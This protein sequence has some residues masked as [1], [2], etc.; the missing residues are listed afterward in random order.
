MPF[1]H[2]PI[3]EVFRL[4]FAKSLYINAGPFASIFYS[5]STP[6]IWRCRPGNKPKQPVVY[7]FLKPL[8]RFTPGAN[9]FTPEGT[10]QKRRVYTRGN[11][12]VE[13]INQ[14]NTPG[15]INQALEWHELKNR[16]KNLANL[17]FY[18]FLAYCNKV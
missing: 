8:P 6:H 13:G 2:L 18:L 15:G 9:P 7:T 12:P 1:G 17:T 4:A 5:T 3:R 11:K 14:G 16:S 10:H